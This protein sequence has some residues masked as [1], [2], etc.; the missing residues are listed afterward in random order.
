[1]I[2]PLEIALSLDKTDVL[3]LE[4]IQGSL[5]ASNTGKEPVTLVA[6]KHNPYHLKL[7][8]IDLQ[9]GVERVF[10]LPAPRNPDLAPPPTPLAPGKS[11]VL[12]FDVRSIAAGI[13]PGEYD[14]SAIHAYGP[15]AEEAESP[16]V[17]LRIRPVTPRNLVLQGIGAPKVVGFWLNMGNGEP[18]LVRTTFDTRPDGGVH[19]LRRLGRVSLRAVPVPSTMP[20]GDLYQWVAWTEGGSGKAL[21]IERLA[22]PSPVKTFPLPA[23]DAVWVAP[24][25]SEAATAENQRPP[26]AALLY[27][28][29]QAQLTAVKLAVEG[30]SRIGAAPLPGPPACWIASIV[31]KDGSKRAMF[32]QAEGGHVRLNDMPWPGPSPAAPR[33]LGDFKGRFMGAACALGA[34]DQILRGSLLLRPGEDALDLERIDFH[35]SADGT[36]TS[37]SVGRIE[38]DPRDL[39]EK[40]LVRIGPEGAVAALFQNGAGLWSI[41]DGKAVVPLPEPIRRTLYPLDLTFR[42]GTEPVILIG[43]KDSGFRIA[44]PDG[45]PL[46]GNPV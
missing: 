45:R 12:A 17:R 38:P 10:Q 8:A 26:G 46:P 13:F 1:M 42:G 40:A 20:E 19:G 6:P 21:H 24:L 16:P 9:T 4:D 44:L 31:R 22:G 30:L 37:A 23:P 15:G 32:V 35:V 2:M 3:H 43:H 33:P 27:S 29:R 5:T 39:P 28:P 18:E 7:R 36:F 11:L 14:V 34:V 41:Y 25:H